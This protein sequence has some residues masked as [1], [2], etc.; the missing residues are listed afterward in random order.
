MGREA[1]RDLP[2]NPSPDPPSPDPSPVPHREPLSTFRKLSQI[3]SDENNHLSSRE[4]LSQVQRPGGRGP[5][6]GKAQAVLSFPCTSEMTLSLRVGSPRFYCLCCP[7][8]SS[9]C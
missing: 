7:P 1:G 3:F 5:G 8:D 9:T 4:I 6:A 2:T